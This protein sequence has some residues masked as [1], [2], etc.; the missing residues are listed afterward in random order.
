[1]RN[2][3]QT[4]GQRIVKGRQGFASMNRERLAEITA[5]GGRAV[6]AAG[7]GHQWDVEQARAAGRKGGLKSAERRKQERLA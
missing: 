2:E 7:T 5:A 6:Q 3:G 4:P 1:M